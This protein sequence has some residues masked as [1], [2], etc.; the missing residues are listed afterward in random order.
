MK[1]LDMKNRGLTVDR[2]KS[3]LDYNP[4]TGVFTWKP[5]KGSCNNMVGKTAGS[6]KRDGYVWICIDGVQHSA[7]RIAWAISRGE[8][9]PEDLMVDHRDTDKSNNRAQN[10]RL[11]TDSQN[12]ANRPL[13]S[14]NTSGYKGVSLNRRSG[15]YVA[16]IGSGVGSRSIPLG[17]YRDPLDAHMAYVNAAIRQYGEFAR[18]S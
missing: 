8:M 5:I 11:A 2:I 10:L 16:K 9:P 4:L 13:M 6:L 17:S 18:F 12:K 14:T 1:D 7:G 15:K 3:L